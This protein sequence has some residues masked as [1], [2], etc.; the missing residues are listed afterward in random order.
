MIVST[1]Y[2]HRRCRRSSALAERSILNTAQGSAS[3]D[4]R[5]QS[6]GA[7]GGQEWLD[8]R[9]CIHIVAASPSSKGLTYEGAT[10]PRHGWV[11][12]QS[13]PE[14]SGLKVGWTVLSE[15]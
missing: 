3:R 13:Y 12:S 9:S 11:I 15:P 14:C 2:N 7:R 4:H 1:G 10:R 6:R 8:P 5:W